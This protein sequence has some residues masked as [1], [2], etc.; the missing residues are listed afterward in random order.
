MCVSQK[1]RFRPRSA[2]LWVLPPNL[3]GPP[4]WWPGEEGS[5]VGHRGAIVG[6]SWQPLRLAILRQES[7]ISADTSKCGEI[8]QILRVSGPLTGSLLRARRENGDRIGREEGP[9]RRQLGGCVQRNQ[10]HGPKKNWPL[11]TGVTRR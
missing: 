8:G 9:M 3:P 4:V 1:R 2:P 7:A 10:W 5:D 11:P 6:Q